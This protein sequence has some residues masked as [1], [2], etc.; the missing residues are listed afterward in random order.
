MAGSD[1]L[2]GVGPSDKDAYKKVNVD[3]REGAAGGEGGD[4]IT[5]RLPCG[6]DYVG[7]SYPTATQ[8]VYVFKAGGSGGTTVGTL[9]INYTTAA[10]E[11]ISDAAWT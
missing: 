7:A 4:L 10:K 5:S 8:E 1:V 6:A 2:I 3:S 9:T 11:F